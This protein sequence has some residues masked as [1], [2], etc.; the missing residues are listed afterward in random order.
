MKKP[1]RISRTL[2]PYQNYFKSQQSLPFTN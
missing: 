1:L 2:S